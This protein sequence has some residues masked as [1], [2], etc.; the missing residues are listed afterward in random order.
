MYIFSYVGVDGRT[1]TI[2]TDPA[3]VPVSDQDNTFDYHIL[4]NVTLMRIVTAA[5]GSPA[6]VTSYHWNVIKCYT[7]LNDLC[8]YRDQTRQNITADNLLARDAGTVN[9]T[10]TISGTDYTSDPLTLRISGELN[11]HF[12]ILSS[13]NTNNLQLRVGSV[14]Y[15]K[16]TPLTLHIKKTYI[17][18]H[19]LLV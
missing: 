3:G 7:I 19:N 1:V 13:K 10:A 11:Q 12:M 5:D 8:F 16:W 9:C 4:T 14:S 18:S 2:V 6:N 15:C 17:I